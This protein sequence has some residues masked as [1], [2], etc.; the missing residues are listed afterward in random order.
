M[1]QPELELVSQMKKLFPGAT[2]RGRASWS[3]ALQ[4]GRSH[5][6][7]VS[8]EDD[9]VILTTGPLG[10]HGSPQSVVA[11]NATLPAASRIVCATDGLQLRAEWALPPDAMISKVWEAV[12]CDFQAGLDILGGASIPQ[13]VT[14]P[15]Y[16]FEREDPAPH[17]NVRPN[18]DGTWS[19]PLPHEKAALHASASLVTARILAQFEYPEEVRAAVAE[20][21]LRGTSYLRFVKACATPDSATQWSAWIQASPA[22]CGTDKALT[23]V[24]LAYGECASAARALSEVRLAR[25]F[26][27]VGSTWR[28]G[29]AAYSK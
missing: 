13:P 15:T 18:G 22:V 14:L 21:L 29:Q 23:G 28:A 24:A 19:V 12:L 9:V 25:R 10:I 3:V 1:L 4:N 26:R 2:P 27:E 17:W 20:L 11:M 5:L 8:L 16:A 7:R 6:S